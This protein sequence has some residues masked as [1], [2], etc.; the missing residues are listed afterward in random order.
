[1]K[2]HLVIFD[3]QLVTVLSVGHQLVADELKRSD[4]LCPSRFRERADR[5]LDEGVFGIFGIVGLN[6]RRR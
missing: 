5:V 2:S 6:R 1:M 3:L 4:W